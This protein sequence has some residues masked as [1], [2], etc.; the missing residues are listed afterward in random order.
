MY[1]ADAIARY[2]R[3][4]VNVTAW[5]IGDVVSGDRDVVWA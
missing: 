5:V 4:E 1:Y 2:L 3:T